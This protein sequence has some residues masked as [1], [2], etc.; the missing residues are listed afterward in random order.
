M[1][2]SFEHVCIQLCGS[3]REHP[4]CL[5]L[6]SLHP[7][8][9][10]C[11]Q[12]RTPSTYPFTSSI[13]PRINSLSPGF[14][15]IGQESQGNGQLVTDTGLTSQGSDPCTCSLRTSGLGSWKG[16]KRSA[17]LSGN[18]PARPPATAAGCCRYR[19]PGGAP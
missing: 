6:G 4:M 7:P 18:W 17:Y 14:R 2:L 3:R 1:K 12:D 9:H 8:S 19:W 11:V 10:L 13:S 15:N 16:A 5:A